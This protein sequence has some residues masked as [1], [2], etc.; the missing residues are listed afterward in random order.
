M[1]MAIYYNLRVLTRIL[2]RAG[3]AARLRRLTIHSIDATAQYGAFDAVMLALHHDITN[4]P[5]RSTAIRQFLQPA[6][7]CLAT[8]FVP[9]KALSPASL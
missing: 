1:K 2:L 6:S 7:Q 8:A 3:G 5:A 9:S 4:S